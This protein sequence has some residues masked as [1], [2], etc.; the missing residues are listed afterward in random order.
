M[1]AQETLSIE[2]ILLPIDLKLKAVGR[3]RH[4]RA[5]LP[6]GRAAGDHHCALRLTT[7]RPLPLKPIA[8]FQYRIL[9]VLVEPMRIALCGGVLTRSRK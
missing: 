4:E 1:F 8:N 9:Y 6:S 3:F 5:S 2:G 7:P